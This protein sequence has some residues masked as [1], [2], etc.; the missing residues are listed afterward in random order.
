MKTKFSLDRTNWETIDVDGVNDFFKDLDGYAP[1]QQKVYFEFELEPQEETIR[2][3]YLR[4]A[5]FFQNK[6]VPLVPVEHEV[7]TING[8]PKLNSKLFYSI[9]LNDTSNNLIIVRPDSNG[10]F[11]LGD[12]EQGKK[13]TLEVTLRSEGGI[14]TNFGEVLK[15][16]DIYFNFACSK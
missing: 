15:V 10:M 4:L 16:S 1:T 11:K 13:L 9:K 8:N 6:E 12:L 7:A 3:I 14:I 5:E 2:N